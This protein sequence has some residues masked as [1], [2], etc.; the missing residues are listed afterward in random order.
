MLNRQDKR[1]YK[2]EKGGKITKVILTYLFTFSLLVI[3]TAYAVEEYYSKEIRVSGDN[4]KTVTLTLKDLE[5]MS[6]V[7]LNN[8]RVYTGVYDY[9]GVPLRDV[10]RRAG[11]P[12]RLHHWGR[13]VFMVKG[14]DGNFAVFS[15]GEI[16]NRR[17]GSRIVI[18]FKRRYAGSQGAFQYLKPRLG[19]MFCL[20]T[21]D[22]KVIDRRTVKWVSDIHI[23]YGGP[24]YEAGTDDSRKGHTK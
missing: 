3:T 17:D 16:F 1:H 20:I 2:L 6:Q 22:D 24:Q 8:V 10:I 13:F 12:K 15:C 21:P 19:G 14:L 7:L 18:V 9:V 11:F 4:A 5:A 23:Y